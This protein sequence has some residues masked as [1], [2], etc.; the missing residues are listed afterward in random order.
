VTPDQRNRL[1]ILQRELLTPPD[2]RPVHE[3]CSEHLVIPPPT[4]PGPVGWAGYE[5][6]REPLD[7]F[8]TPGVTDLALCFGSQTGKTTMVMAGVAW[9]LC[10]D[11]STILWAMPNEVLARSFSTT[12]FRPMVEASAPLRG[13]VPIGNVKRSTYT[14]MQMALG[15]SLLTFVGSHSPANTS[16]RPARKVVM[17]EVD[18]LGDETEREAQAVEQLEART[19]AQPMPLRV[20][21]ST[22]TISSGAVWV[23]FRNGDQRRYYL[24]CPACG[25][26]FVLAWSKEFTI[27]PEADTAFISWPA[28]CRRPDGTWDLDAVSRQ[29]V[30]TCPHC[31][32][33]IHDSSKTRMVRFGEWRPTASGAAGCRSYH[34]PSLYSCSPQTSWGAIAVRF[35]QAK[36]NLLGLKGFVTN[37]LAEPWENQDTLT[38]RVEIITEMAREAGAGSRRIMTVDCQAKSPHFWYVVR[39][40]EPGD[41]AASCGIVAGSCE[42][43]EDLRDIQVANGVHD[44]GVVVDSG[45]GARDDAEVYRTCAR[46]GAIVPQGKD[47]RP[48]CLGWMPAKGMPS[49]RRWR[50]EKGQHLPYYLRNIDP[51]SGTGD[52]GQVDMSLF[53]F[54]GDFFK[55]VL[56]AMRDPARS[57]DTRVEWSVS[58]AMATTEYWRHMDGEVKTE[59]RNKRNGRTVWEW[60]LRSDRWPNHLFDCEVQ[61]VAAA[62]FFGLLSIPMEDK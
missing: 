5:Y 11:P 25:E 15:G 60:H 10:E 42:T 38:Q 2:R 21:T 8:N 51:F 24:P 17:D 12:R 54:S 43:W 39:Q 20:K 36:T 9:S 29:T 59:V 32:S 23:A 56:S 30:A 50:D 35:L 7:A 45:Y 57:K 41:T 48:L 4:G 62:M 44:V 22:P 34:L 31:Q 13:R 61:Q 55:D 16:S 52:A 37:E 28:S 46:F 18:K 27:F 40:W 26:F 49:R 1:L 33:Q 53:E 19:K 47:R 14:T 58:K 6:L 3:W